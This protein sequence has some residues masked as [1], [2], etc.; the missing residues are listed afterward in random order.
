MQQHPRAPLL[1]FDLDGTLA[2]T[3]SDLVATLNIILAREGL[4]GITVPAARAMVGGGARALIQRGLSAN[5]KNA[6]EIR[7]DE[8]LG[9]FLAYYE[10]HVADETVLFVGVRRQLDCL[11][12]AGVSLAV[13][14][15]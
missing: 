11:G 3:A 4:A 13:F 15:G 9:D 1:V 7:V 14:T 10:A 2:D 12:A 8:M 5:G 6:S